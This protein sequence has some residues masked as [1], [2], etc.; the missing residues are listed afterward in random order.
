MTTRILTEIKKKD[1]K[2]IWVKNF[3]QKM[4]CNNLNICSKHVVNK[5]SFTF[6]SLY[7]QQF[8][9][10]CLVAKVYNM[11]CVFS[12]NINYIY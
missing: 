2:G 10:Y 1:K 11:E 4:D 6:H 3:E 8:V 12:K 9:A 7:K 5:I